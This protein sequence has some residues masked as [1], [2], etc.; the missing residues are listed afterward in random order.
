MWD[1]SVGQSAE[2]VDT[3]FEPF[4]KGDE[5]KQG[6]GLGLAYCHETAEKLGG[7]LVFD[8]NYHEGASFILT[9]PINLTQ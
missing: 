1:A 6:L 3:I 4:I 5:F 9:L 8:K 2:K 7:S